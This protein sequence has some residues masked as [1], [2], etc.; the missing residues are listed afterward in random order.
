LGENR[1]LYGKGGEFLYRVFGQQKGEKNERWNVA[2]VGMYG[3]CFGVVEC[4]K[5][6]VVRPIE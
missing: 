4:M 6:Q 3:H 1:N 2:I 5:K